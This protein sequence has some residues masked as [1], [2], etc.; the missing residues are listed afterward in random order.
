MIR[1]R[2]VIHQWSELRLGPL[3]LWGQW[4]WLRSNTEK[5]EHIKN[6][7][8]TERPRS[9]DSS[10][11]NQIAT[12]QATHLRVVGLWPT[13][14][15]S[16]QTSKA[17]NDCF[18]NAK[19][20]WLNKHNNKYNH[21]QHSMRSRTGGSSWSRARGLEPVGGVE[22]TKEAWWSGGWCKNINSKAIPNSIC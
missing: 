7:Q 22:P 14:I 21:F 16:N 19:N 6:H 2:C 15:T 3:V 12:K 4:E 20:D 9:S 1:C 8:Q 17:K 10:E 13:N 11:S 18:R 5:R